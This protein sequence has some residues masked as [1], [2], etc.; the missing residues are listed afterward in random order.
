MGKRWRSAR[1]WSALLKKV[2]EADVKGTRP[3]RRSYKLQATLKDKDASEADKTAAAAAIR[4][5]LAALSVPREDKPVYQVIEPLEAQM[6]H[7][8]TKEPTA[9]A[10]A[11]KLQEYMGRW[12][13]STSTR[14]TPPA[15]SAAS[16]TLA[17]RPSATANA[18]GYSRTVSAS[19]LLRSRR[20]AR[21]G[22][23]PDGYGRRR[24]V[25]TITSRSW[26]TAVH[27]AARLGDAGLRRR[28]GQ[29]ALDLLGFAQGSRRRHLARL[30][31]TG[32]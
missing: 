25:P 9:T 24:R 23:A 29:D 5:Q 13:P 1:R 4:K 3:T 15:T 20:Q 30:L 10:M 8:D 11:Q 28:D 31:A 7:K 26:S 6:A 32:A 12:G 16:A 17:R 2:D 27:R 14:S 21:V 22:D 18:C 19:R